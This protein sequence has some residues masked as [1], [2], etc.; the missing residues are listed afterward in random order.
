MPLR[1]KVGKG[2]VSA[3]LLDGESVSNVDAKDMNMGLLAMVV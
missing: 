1:S 2:V 3:V